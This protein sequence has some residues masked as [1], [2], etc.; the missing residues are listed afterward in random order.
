M[1]PGRKEK[2]G[3]DDEDQ[4]EKCEKGTPIEKAP[5]FLWPP[6]KAK[7]FRHSP[8]DFIACSKSDKEDLLKAHVEKKAETGLSK[9]TRS[10]TKKEDTKVARR[11]GFPSSP[12]SSSFTARF[13]D[14]EERLSI[15]S[16]ADDGSDESII[17]AKVAEHV[18]LNGVGKIHRIHSI[19]FQIALKTDM[20]AQSFT[21]SG[22]RAPPRKVLKL[23]AGPL[24]LNVRYLVAGSSLTA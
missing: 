3:H 15:T 4:E 8:K 22:T 1:K 23:C 21:F 20:E 13:H 12:Q 10:Y 7:S 24:S 17:S 11:T 18:I 2:D 14:G 16:R 5:M 6:D 19:T 9:G